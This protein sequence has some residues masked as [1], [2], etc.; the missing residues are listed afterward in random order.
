MSLTTY[1]QSVA[2]ILQ[3]PRQPG[4]TKYIDKLAVTIIGRA[5]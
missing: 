3:Q 5:G 2:E 1:Q 4:T